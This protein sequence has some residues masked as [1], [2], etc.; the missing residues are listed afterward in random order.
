MSSL[1]VIQLAE[2]PFGAKSKR[3]MDIDLCEDELFKMRADFAREPLREDEL[4][5]FFEYA[6]RV[7]APVVTVDAD[8]RTITFLDPKTVL[9]AYTND[10]ALKTTKFLE[11]LRQGKL[12]HWKYRRAI[13]APFGIGDLIYGAGGDFCRTLPDVLEDYT[14]GY[15]ART[16]YFGNILSCHC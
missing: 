16:M 2:E 11:S 9:E 10:F 13:D 8:K 4:P 7:F 12:D 15:V 3:I 14:K 1:Y 5:R 6:S